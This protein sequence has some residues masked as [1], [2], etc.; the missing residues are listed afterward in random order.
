ME[1]RGTQQKFHG[2]GLRN[3]GRRMQLVSRHLRRDFVFLPSSVRKAPLFWWFLFFLMGMASVPAPRIGILFLSIIAFGFYLQEKKSAIGLILMMCVCAGLGW[4]RL[5]M[6][7]T[8]RIPA[9]RGARQWTGPIRKFLGTIQSSG[10]TRTGR[11]RLEVL[12]LE[13]DTFLHGRTRWHVY[14][15]PDTNLQA[16]PGDTLQLTWCRFSPLAPPRNPGQFDFR[17]YAHNHGIIGVLSLTD[18]TALTLRRHTGL[19]A[20]GCAWQVR[21][22]VH[23]QLNRYVPE[24]ES[25]FLEA[26]LLGEKSDLD[27]EL[28]TAFRRIGVIHVLAVSGLHVGYILIIILLL[29]KLLR[30]P[31]GWDRLAIVL[32]LAG[33]CVVTGLRS[34]V[35][36]AAGMAALYLCGPL[37]NRRPNP[38]NIL[39][40]VGLTMILVEPL[41][42]YDMG[43]QLSF[44]AVFSILVY[45][46]YLEPQIPDRW[47]I[48]RIHSPIV[49]GFLEL[50]VIST[51]AQLGTLPLLLPRTHQIPLLSMVANGLIVPLVGVIVS[52]GFL[53]L[54]VSFVP[55]IQAVIAN[56]LWL[57]IRLVET[58]ARYLSAPAFATARVSGDGIDV[59]LIVY[60]SV[61]LS[62]YCLN[63]RPF[64]YFLLGACLCWSLLVWH[65]ASLRNELEAVFLDV[66]QGDAALIRLPDRKT[67]VIDTGPRTYYR[68]S[69]RDVLLPALVALGVR[70][71]QWLVLTHAHADHIGGTLSVLKQIPVDTLVIPMQ[72]GNTALIRHIRRC[73][74][75]LHVAVDTI[76]G[77]K[78][79]LHRDY[80]IQFLWPLREA[81][82][83]NQNN[84]NI[85]CTVR[86]SGGSLLFTGD[87]EQDGERALLQRW[88]TVPT[89]VLKVGH[90]GSDTGT[91]GPFLEA[92]SP[93]LAVIS[94]GKGNK[95]G[96]PSPEVIQ[97][98]HDHQVTIH[99]TDRRQALWLRFHQSNWDSVTWR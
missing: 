61:F 90:H 36:R 60:G 26:V 2:E 32:A 23:R 88:D 13:P 46:T 89:T 80:L 78:S 47:R 74:D 15:Y 69:G 87:L 5:E 96:H 65:R 29:T 75:S 79:I 64:R 1:G 98:L 4:I 81:A 93:K 40:A 53:Y 18:S 83:L 45:V 19:T 77:P 20:M 50:M 31:W 70:E 57:C 51:M 68:D 84:R 48:R 86:T 71:I 67:M 58:T 38:Y 7:Q 95:F 28:Q 59:I 33:Y 22:W 9:F 99:R 94:V 55:L 42:V 66:G 62:L 14:V 10:I 56:S 92:L 35:I 76:R 97:R 54:V 41:S 16:I 44:A 85:V 11:Y 17:S 21:R 43:F 6:R 63:R 30:I 91:T 24:R 25:G 82:E 39:G 37:V 3:T 12:W 8:D 73:A 34:S 49:R 72:W 27:D 52:L